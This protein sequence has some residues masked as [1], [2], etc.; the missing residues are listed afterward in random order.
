MKKKGF[1]LIEL[2]ATL[3]ILSIVSGI[4]IMTVNKQ[5]GKSKKQGAIESAKAYIK[6]FETYV[7]D[8]DL[9][10]DDEEENKDITYK[11]YDCI[12]NVNHKTR[13]FNDTNENNDKQICWANDI[14]EAQI[15]P[16]INDIISYTGSK[17]IG[18]YDY[19]EFRS[20]KVI[21]AYL[22]FKNANNDNE[23][24]NNITVLYNGKKFQLFEETDNT[25][26]Y[27]YSG[28]DENQSKKL[29]ITQD[30]NIQGVIEQ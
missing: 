22:T 7:L 2:L 11:I 6:L 23:D 20:G 26:D 4:A 24:S 13:V 12:Y 19:I 25:S 3:V 16:S 9:S 21:Q 28:N 1:T 30:D 5:Y 15:Y 14:T 8:F 18:D 10:L 17:P 29:D 27:D